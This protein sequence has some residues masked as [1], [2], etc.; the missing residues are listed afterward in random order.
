MRHSEELTSVAYVCPSC[1]ARFLARRNHNAATCPYCGRA[2]ELS[3]VT[4]HDSSLAIVPFAIARDKAEEI[5][6]KHLGSKG[7]LR[8]RT[9]PAIKE[10]HAVNIPFYLYDSFVYGDVDFEGE[11]V[12]GY[13]SRDTAHFH[14]KMRVRGYGEFASL[15]IC[16][17]TGLPGSIVE[18]I[19]PYDLGESRPCNDSDSICHL[20][21]TSRRPKSVVSARANE[22][23]Y[24]VF[25]LHAFRYVDQT[26]QEDL[27]PVLQNTS[28]SFKERTYPIAITDGPYDRGHDIAVLKSE[29]IWLPLWII[30]C[31]WKEEDRLFIINGQTGEHADV[32]CLDSMGRPKET[33]TG[34]YPIPTDSHTSFRHLRVK[35]I[36][37]Y[38]QSGEYWH[39]THSIF[40]PQNHSGARERAGARLCDG[41]RPTVQPI[42]STHAS[43]RPWAHSRNQAVGPLRGTSS[44]H[45]R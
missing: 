39:D 8:K 32:W 37:P 24:G 18:K 22:V 30:R 10:V 14:Y 12:R 35:R 3:E 9:I 33:S 27:P 7:L 4:M 40:E 20:V 13:G 25:L 23:A 36:T 15:T 6:I 42:R 28:L 5:V 41:N 31:S 34:S 38:Y 17:S 21:E 1:A 26:A 43:S 2:L 11:G 19:L 44:T 16:A 45:I 29:L